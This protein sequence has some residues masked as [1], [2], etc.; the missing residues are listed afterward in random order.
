MPKLALS[1]FEA[2]LLFALFTSVVLGVVTKNTDKERLR[3]GLYCF[4]CFMAAM[5]GLSWLMYF[6]HQ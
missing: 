1:H 4:G 6:A 3:Y 5:F 2:A